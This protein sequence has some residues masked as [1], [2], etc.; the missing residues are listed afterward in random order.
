MGAKVMVLAA[1]TLTPAS[2]L[3]CEVK[4]PCTPTPA[5][6]IPIRG[7]PGA[8]VRVIWCKNVPGESRGACDNDSYA[9]GERRLRVAS[10]T[11][12]LTLKGRRGREL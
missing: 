7:A 4:A 1:Q 5:K 3:Q 10:V 12:E 6:Y 8:S 9:N 11:W 2:I